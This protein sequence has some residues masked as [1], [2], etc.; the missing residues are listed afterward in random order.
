[1]SFKLEDIIAKI[2]FTEPQPTTR[3]MPEENP[4]QSSP[5]GDEKSRIFGFQGDM[6][7]FRLDRFAPTDEIPP[8]ASK[9]PVDYFEIDRQADELIKTHTDDGFFD[10]SLKTD[11]LGKDL[12]DIARTDP[13]RARALT[14]N[15]L[16]KID[17]SDRDEVAQS[18]VDSMKP[19]ELRALAGSE[20]GRQMLEQLKGKLVSGSVHD[21][22]EKTARRIDTA[23]KGAELEASNAFKSLSPET[24]NEIRA[25]LNRDDSNS[26]AIDNLLEMV[27]SG[28]FNG[29]S[30]D[31]QIAMLKALGN[32]SEDANFREALVNLSNNGDFTALDAAAQATVIS[33]LD[34]FANTESYKGKDGSWFFNMGAH[35]VS[36]SDKKLL[37]D[38]IGKVAIFSAQ[39][40]TNTI[41][42]NT[43][44]H[45]VGGDVHLNLYEEKPEVR[46][47][48]IYSE[49]GNAGDSTTVNLNKLTIGNDFHQFVDTLAHETNHVLNA[50]ANGGDL[51]EYDKPERFIDE[52]RAFITGLEGDGQSLSG[53]DIKS[54][55]DNLCHTKEAA[56]PNLR[57]LYDNDETFRG[58]IDQA[59]K[60]AD[61][62][63][64]ISADD[65]EKRIIAAGLNSDYLDNTDN[66]DNR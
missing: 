44:E 52:Y 58:V 22:E 9:P 32:H 43:L 31:T 50:R 46:N 56:Y 60:D 29:A 47:G 33:N 26:T 21:D 18:L 10:D 63:Q 59:Y 11:D 30:K 19:E 55:L 41:I 17:D 48:I 66:T 13:A 62:G 37:L 39:N 64:F 49:Y 14:D 45:I 35:S 65:M 42:R 34:R 61:S 54:I 57:E 12:A 25:Q 27:K 15:V 36:D 38:E 40:P 4:V 5:V 3:A 53:S 24:Q 28:G 7:R 8:Q 1:M 51:S 16:D 23:I 6:T 2:T 20:D